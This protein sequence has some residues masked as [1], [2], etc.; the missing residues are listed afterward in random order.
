[1]LSC[2]WARYKSGLVKKEAVLNSIM[3]VHCYMCTLHTL[4]TL[5]WPKGSLLEEVSQLPVIAGKLHE[6]LNMGLIM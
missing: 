1:M 5:I 2:L 6:G 4:L 3:V